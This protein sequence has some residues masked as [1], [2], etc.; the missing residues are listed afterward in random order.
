MKINKI[1]PLTESSLSRVWQHVKSNRPFAII[2]AFRESDSYEMN[3]QKNRALA[4]SLRINGYGYFFLEGHFLEV[5]PK[6]G[7]QIKVKEESIFVAG[8][9]KDSTPEGNKK[10]KNALAEGAMEYEQ[11]SFIMKDSISKSVILYNKQGKEIKD[12]GRIN[13]SNFE[14]AVS[15]LFSTYKRS[16]KNFFMK[17]LDRLKNIFIKNKEPDVQGFSKLKNRGE[18]VFYFEGIEHGVGFMGRLAGAHRNRGR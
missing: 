11:D 12:L 7:K 10:M 16:N 18:R 3:I 9:N 14:K 4:A 5:N 6:T 15:L 2:T 1:R 13:P 17:G 8:G